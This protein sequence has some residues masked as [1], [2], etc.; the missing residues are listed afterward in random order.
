M[1]FVASTDF[2]YAHILP[3]LDSDAAALGAKVRALF[4]SRGIRSVAAEGFKAP[5]VVV[6]YTSDADIQKLLASDIGGMNSDMGSIQFDPMFAMEFEREAYRRIGQALS[7]GGGDTTALLTFLPK[8]DPADLLL[9]VRRRHQRRRARLAGT[10]G[11]GQRLPRL[12]PAA[13]TIRENV[14]RFQELEEGV[15]ARFGA[16]GDELVGHG[17]V[18]VLCC[19]G[20]T[21]PTWPARDTK[22][23]H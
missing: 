1:V 16:H 9:V 2:A 10:D 3:G 22:G 20:C 23:K 15:F 5:G 19:N 12:T 6:S 13:Q 17:N 4:E 14:D 21:I 11:Q 8:L 18:S 7:A